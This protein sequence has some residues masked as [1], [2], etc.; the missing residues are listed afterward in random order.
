MLNDRDSNMA[1]NAICHSASMIQESFSVI[2]YESTRPSVL[3]KPRV[4]Q[5]GNKWC[6]L[7]GDD[8]QSG[9]CGFGDS[10]ADATWNFDEQW[11]T[12]CKGTA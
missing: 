5:D 11:S 7:L 12:K 4:F 6:A 8:L 2:A 10:P 3:F 1:A 9:V